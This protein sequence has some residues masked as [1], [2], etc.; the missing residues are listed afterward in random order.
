M[1][2]RSEEPLDHLLFY[3]EIASA[4]WSTIFGC[5]GLAWVMPK[6]VVDFFACWRGLRGSPQSSTVW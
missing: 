3:F 2:K 5:V 1:C 6:R 4:L